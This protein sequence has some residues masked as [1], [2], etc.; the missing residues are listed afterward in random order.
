MNFLNIISLLLNVS[1]YYAVEH[2]TNNFQ[3][4]NFCKYIYFYTSHTCGDID[5]MIL[6]GLLFRFL[7]FNY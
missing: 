1:F 6:F 3:L 4:Y 7:F 2:K 5:V